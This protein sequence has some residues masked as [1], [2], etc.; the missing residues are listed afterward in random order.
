MFGEADGAAGCIDDRM[1]ADALVCAS[2]DVA[3]SNAHITRNRARS[4]RE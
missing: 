1:P 4:I 3:P 2:S